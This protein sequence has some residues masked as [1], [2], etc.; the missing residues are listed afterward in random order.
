MESKQPLVTIIIPVY[1]GADFLR[2]C[3]DSALAQTYD[4]KEIIVVNDGSCDNGKTEEIALSYGDKIR[5]IYKENGGVS[6][7]LNL[8]IKNMQGEYFS[9]LSH[10]DKYLPDKVK[11]SVEL[12]AKYDFNEKLIAYTGTDFIDENSQPI[13]KKWPIDFLSDKIIPSQDVLEAML[14][15][16]SLS[17]CA[18]LIPKSAFSECGNFDE[19]LRF[20]QDIL[21]WYR[22]FG[23]GYKVAADSQKNVLSRL[24]SNQVTQTRQDLYA[25]DCMAISDELSDIFL[26]QENKAKLFC[27]YICDSAKRNVYEVAR[28]CLRKNKK[29]HVLGFSEFLRIRAFFVYGKIRIVLKKIYYK[30]VYKVNIK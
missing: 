8:G 13:N 24:H 27:L 6:T 16:G 17:G 23:K 26:S 19:S 5:Y 28:K 15:H 12:L 1:N 9:W 10:D 20:C 7:A 29:T 2:E 30:L 3:I 18:L 22:L 4:N 25:S 11:T 14:R 21:M